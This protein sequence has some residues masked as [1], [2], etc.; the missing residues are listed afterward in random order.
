MSGVE[1]GGAGEEWIGMFGGSGGDFG[2]SGGELQV[3]IARCG[4]GGLGIENCGFIRF[5]GKLVG[6]TQF[7]VDFRAGLADGFERCDG[8]GIIVGLA[9]ET[10][11]GPLY[12]RVLRCAGLGQFQIVAGLIEVLQSLMAEDAISIRISERI[13][14]DSTLP[15]TPVRA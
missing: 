14:S 2:L 6:V 12:F 10:C 7:R 5:S 15:S 4:I 11:Q 1:A 8:R 9:I 3:H 13:W